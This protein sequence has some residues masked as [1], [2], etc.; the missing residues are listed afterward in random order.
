MTLDVRERLRH[1]RKAVDPR[2]F[3]FATKINVFGFGLM[4]L[5]TAINTLV[6]PTRVADTTTSGVE[7]SGL[8]LISFI[9]VGFAVL[10]Q[11][12]AGRASDAWTRSDPRRPFIIAGIVLIV[13]GLTLFGGATTFLALTLGFVLMQLAT[14]VSQAAF[15]AFIPDHIE[16]DDRGIA[17]GAKNMLSV[18]GAA[19]GL[20]GTQLILQQGGSTRLVLVFLGVTI[21][22]DRPPHPVLGP[23]YREG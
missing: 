16:E 22:G 13:P 11:P 3:L 9:G 19:V 23:A 10:V 20:I 21:V 5:W 7:G 1:I 14:N 12:L 6:L 4:V 8:G 17:S 18:V 15:Q 2:T